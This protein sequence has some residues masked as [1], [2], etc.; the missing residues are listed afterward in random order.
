MEIIGFLVIVIM[1]VFIIVIF[2]AL[3]SNPDE[4]VNVD[5]RESA[6]VENLLNSLMNYKYCDIS[7]GKKFNEVIRN[8]YLSDGDYCNVYCKDYIKDTVK[9]A[10]DKYGCKDYFFKIKQDEDV[11][12]S[13]GE[14]SGRVKT[15]QFNIVAGTDYLEIIMGVCS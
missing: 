4:D 1:I 11:F 13:D 14:C 3:S 9:N 8:C 10:C 5:I 6:E 7:S 15:G 12:L 2:V